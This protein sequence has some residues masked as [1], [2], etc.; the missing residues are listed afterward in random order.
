L[1]TCR[2][3][4]FATTPVLSPISEHRQSVIAISL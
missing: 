1:R 4:V 3:T 2:R